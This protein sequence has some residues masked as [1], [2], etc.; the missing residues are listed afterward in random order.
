MNDNQIANELEE[1]AACTVSD[2]PLTIA[3]IN[4]VCTCG[5]T[6]Q[7]WDFCRRYAGPD[8]IHGVVICSN[9]HKVAFAVHVG[10]PQP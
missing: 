7:P 1:M 5:R 8:A 9:C 3:V 2:V 6:L 10:E 4:A